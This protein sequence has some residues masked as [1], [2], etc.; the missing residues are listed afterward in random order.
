VVPHPDLRYAVTVKLTPA[1]KALLAE[2]G[3]AFELV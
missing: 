2:L 3:C 1:G